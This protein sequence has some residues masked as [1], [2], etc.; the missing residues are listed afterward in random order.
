VRVHRLDADLVE[1]VD[2][3]CRADKAEPGT[4]KNSYQNDVWE[5][6]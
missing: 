1:Q 4:A 2:G 6:R 3:R 5:Y